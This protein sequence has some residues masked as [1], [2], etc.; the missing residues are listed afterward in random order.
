VDAAE[1]YEEDLNEGIETREEEALTLFR[2]GLIYA[3]D[4][5]SLYDP[6]RSVEM[7]SRCLEVEPDSAFEL[8]ARLLLG[9]EQEVVRLRVDV[10][11]RKQRIE[12]LFT[13]LS[14]LQEKIER[15]EGQVG[16][17]EQKVDTLSDQIDSLRQKIDSLMRE[18][19]EKEVELERL[20]AIDLDSEQ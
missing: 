12:I 20:K 18:V 17:R 9:L 1:A 3:R 10:A 8:Q 14:E 16:A 5:S 19:E 2:L 6:S 15:A 7:L 4:E 11:K 13:E